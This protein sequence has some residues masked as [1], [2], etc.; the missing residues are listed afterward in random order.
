[1]K[2]RNKEHQT[3]GLKEL[4]QLSE[5]FPNDQK[6]GQ[7]IRKLSSATVNNPKGTSVYEPQI[8][9]KDKD[10]DSKE[11]DKIDRYP[12]LLTPHWRTFT[13]F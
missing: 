1:M 11:E 2:I 10:S 12:P 9:T 6:L 7:Y 3:L 5:D 4:Q 8:R 13:S